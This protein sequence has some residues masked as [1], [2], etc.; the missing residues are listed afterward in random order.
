MLTWHF[1]SFWN[2]N[3]SWWSC[4]WQGVRSDG[5]DPLERFGCPAS[6]FLVVFSAAAHSWAGCC[7]TCSL[8][9]SSAS[10]FCSSNLIIAFP[11][12]LTVSFCVLKYLTSPCRGRRVRLELDKLVQVKYFWSKLV[13][14]TVFTVWVWS[15]YKEKC[16]SVPLYLPWLYINARFIDF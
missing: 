9:C 11:R 10:C 6:R 13:F 12:P 7:F 2:A 8:S 3:G 14:C 16:W 5:R 1:I 4:L 15:N